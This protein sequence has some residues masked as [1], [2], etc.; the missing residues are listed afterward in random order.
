MYDIRRLRMLLEIHERGTL[1]AAA[2]TLHL[3][4]SAIS[5]QIATLEK[6]VGCK[7]LRHVG[8]R[9]QLTE[10]ALVVVEGAAVILREMDAIGTRVAQL[11]GKAAGT[12]KLALFQSAAIALL[13]PT[14]E[15][16]REHAPKVVLEVDQIDP[17]SGLALTK[18]REFD[19]VIAESYPH[20]FIPEHPDLHS[21]LIATDPIHLIV[22][23]SSGIESL[24]QAH[25][26]PFALEGRQN[27]SRTWAINQCRAEGFEPHVRYD[28]EDLMTHVALVKSGFTAAILPGFIV[29]SIQDT[30]G[31]RILEMPGSPAR[32]IMFTTRVDTTTQPAII[33]V[34]EA[35]QYAC[36]QLELP[37]NL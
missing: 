32:K 18:S 5:Q 25:E 13:G 6:E 4:P 1:A 10:E 17:E 8:R 37:Y 34:R 16:L 30:Y 23:E 27:T 26:I 11:S 33:A 14:L 9:V 19:I 7:L 28:I 36:D 31:I 12:I 24:K 35:L 22:P 21:E 3:T 15:Y 20:H 2:H 29:S